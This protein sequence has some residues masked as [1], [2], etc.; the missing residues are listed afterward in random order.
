MKALVK[1]DAGFASQVLL[2]DGQVV[3]LRDLL[4]LPCLTIDLAQNE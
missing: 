1:D 2:A 4:F 3:C